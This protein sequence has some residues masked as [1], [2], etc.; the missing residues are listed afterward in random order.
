MS[1]SKHTDPI[2]REV[3]EFWG[4]FAWFD[5]QN[6]DDNKRMNDWLRATLTRVAEKARRDENDRIWHEHLGLGKDLRK[7][8]NN[9]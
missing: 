7:V 6:S 9:D 5:L 1:T 2:E 3:E 4:K 8:L